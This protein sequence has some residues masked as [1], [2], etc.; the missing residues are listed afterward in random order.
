[1]LYPIE[2]LGPCGGNILAVRVLFVMFAQAL[3]GTSDLAF[4][5]EA[6][7]LGKLNGP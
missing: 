6:F 2:L 3:A 5:K 7:C 1:M 4:F